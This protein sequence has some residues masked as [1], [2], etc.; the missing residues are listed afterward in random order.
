MGEPLTSFDDAV[1]RSDFSLSRYTNQA[2]VCAQFQFVFPPRL[3]STN[4]KE[5]EA[6]FS[7]RGKQTEPNERDWANGRKEKSKQNF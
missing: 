4:K 5:K 2:K 6:F 3:E 1:R 7:A